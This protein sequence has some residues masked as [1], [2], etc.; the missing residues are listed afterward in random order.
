MPQYKDDL[1]AFL[2]AWTDQVGLTAWGWQAMTTDGLHLCV[3]QLLIPLE[4]WCRWHCRSMKGVRI[5]IWRAGSTLFLSPAL[6]LPPAQE[7]TDMQNLTVAIAPPAPNWL[8]IIT[9]PAIREWA[10][11]LHT[12]WGQLGRQV[13]ARGRGAATALQW[14]S[15]REGALQHHIALGRPAFHH[16]PSMNQGPS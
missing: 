12:T 7:G 4:H 6:P 10:D 1:A 11:F 15:C 2:E 5:E 16:K 14:L 9:D 8:P 3:C 13:G